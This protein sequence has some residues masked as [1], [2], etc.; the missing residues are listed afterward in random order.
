[1]RDA[2]GVRGVERLRDRAQDRQRLGERQLAAALEQRIERLAVEV[3]H[4]VVL[5]AVGEL[6]ERE[7]V[8]DVAVADLVDRARLG[9]EPRH[10][11][12]FDRELAREHLDRD[13]PC[14]SAGGPPCRRCRT[15]P[16]P[17]LP[18]TRYSPTTCPASRSG[19]TA[20]VGTSDVV[21]PLTAIVRG[22]RRTARARNG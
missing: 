6:A 20:A 15:P 18:S 7:D 19:S 16:C 13:A 22:A 3:L 9:D 4:H 10:H 1:M 8:D 2:L 5:A 11:L 21:M 14:R 17:S 12:G